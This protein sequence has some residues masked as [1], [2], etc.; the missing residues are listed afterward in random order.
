MEDV[1]LLEMFRHNSQTLRKLAVF[2]KAEKEGVF[3][4]IGGLI[5]H[6]FISHNCGKAGGY[7][8]HPNTTNFFIMV[9]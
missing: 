8:I 6:G 3:Q 9:L 4:S 7:Q 5:S 2:C 1:V